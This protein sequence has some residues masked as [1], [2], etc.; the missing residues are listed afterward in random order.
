MPLY[1]YRCGKCGRKVE[2]LRSAAELDDPVRCPECGG[3]MKRVLSAPGAI[4]M[5]DGRTPGTTCCGRSERCDAPPCS[6]GSC[7]RN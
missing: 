7:S 2:E 1:E 4:R 3:P 5:G 6:D